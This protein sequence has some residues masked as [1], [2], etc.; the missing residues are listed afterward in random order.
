M[1][2]TIERV[3]QHITNA[4]DLLYD[5]ENPDYKNSVKESISAVELVCAKITGQNAAVLSKALDKIEKDGIVYLHPALKLA[6]EKLY[7]YTS[8]GSG[9]RHAQIDDDDITFEMAQFFLVV[10]S[11]FTNYL[12]ALTAKKKIGLE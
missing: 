2:S 11:A 1:H 8:S 10:C 7:G 5:R 12:I 4:M 9:I 6:L 3:G